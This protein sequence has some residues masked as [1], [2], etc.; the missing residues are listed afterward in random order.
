MIEYAYE[1]NADKIGR[2]CPG[3]DILIRHENEI[4]N[5]QPDYLIVMPYSFVN[6]LL[7][8]KSS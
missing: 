7:K 1:K 4:L 2:Y 3:S 8:K 5:D 6:S